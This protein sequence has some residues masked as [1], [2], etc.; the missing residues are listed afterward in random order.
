MKLGRLLIITYIYSCVKRAFVTLDA[1]RKIRIG[2]MQ[3]RGQ[4]RK[5]R[6]EAYDEE[7]AAGEVEL[8][9]RSIDGAIDD[10]ADTSGLAK[11][12]FG[13]FGKSETLIQDRWG[14]LSKRRK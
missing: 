1:V 13:D 6:M 10:A 9:H 11:T 12:Q 5:K 3:I 14:V 7:T 4:E 8:T 2:K